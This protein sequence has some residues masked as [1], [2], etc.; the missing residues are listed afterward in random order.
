MV[1]K[2]ATALADEVVLDLEDAVAAD[3][4]T[5]RMARS[6]LADLLESVDFGARSVAVRINSVRGPA[7]LQDLLELIPRVGSRLSTLVIPKV[8][9]PSEVGFV[10]HCLDALEQPGA[11]RLGLEIQIE[12]PVGL[13]AVAELAASS[14]RLEAL[15][16]GPGDF[17]AAMGMPLTAIGAAA[18][19]YPGDVWHYPLF[20]IA[21]AARAAGL[22]VIDGPYAQLA[23]PSGLDSACRRAAAIGVDGKWAIHPDQLA[24]I[25]S[26]FTPSAAQLAR[27]REVLAAVSARGG[28]SRLGQEMVDEANRRMAQTVLARSQQVPS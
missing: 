27:A 13:E 21:V 8:S 7:A 6:E 14:S 18:E 1:A 26:A 12:D 25:N 24:T 10:E 3:D 4:K 15:I 5:R 22:Q 23:D 19:G 17:A 9:H 11:P 2:A 28:A 20:R 16:F